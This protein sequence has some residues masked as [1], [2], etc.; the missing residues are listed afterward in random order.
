VG[1]EQVHQVGGRTAGLSQDQ[2]AADT[3]RGEKIV[4]D[5]QRG[6]VPAMVADMA[7]AELGKLGVDATVGVG[8]AADVDGVAEVRVDAH[9]VDEAI[10]AARSFGSGR[11][12]PSFD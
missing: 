1:F 11:G 6:V 4:D 7:N 9:R 5:R 8:V 3:V 12:S 2:V 10:G